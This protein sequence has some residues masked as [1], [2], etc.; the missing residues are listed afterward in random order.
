MEE[1]TSDKEKFTVDTK[2]LRVV[3]YNE[4]WKHS[5]VIT[6]LDE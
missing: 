5:E 2:L 3:K 4:A 1:R 6:R